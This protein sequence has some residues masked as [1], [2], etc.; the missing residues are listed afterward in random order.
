MPSIESV[1]VTRI[2]A[3]SAGIEVFSEL[4]D[5]GSSFALEEDSPLLSED[6]SAFSEEEVADVAEEV[7]DS[8]ALLETKK[9]KFGASI[10]KKDR[11]CTMGEA[12]FCLKWRG[13]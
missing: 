11:N 13:D 5:W 2:L 9:L 8:V 10:T 12:V 4:L 6:V 7:A 3:M 1:Q